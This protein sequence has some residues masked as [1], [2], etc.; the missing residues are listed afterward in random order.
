MDSD[1]AHPGAGP[2]VFNRHNILQLKVD[3]FG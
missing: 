2:E 3:G 1:L